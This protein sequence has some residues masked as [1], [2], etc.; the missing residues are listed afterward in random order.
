MDNID[1]SKKISGV[2]VNG[3]NMQFDASV[4]ANIKAENIKDGV[5][6]LGVEGTFEGG[7]LQT[8]QISIGRNGTTVVLPDNGFFGLEKVEII[9][10]V[11]PSDNAI[12]G[13]SW[14]NDAT[15]TMTRTDDAEDMTYAI[16][17]GRVASDFDNVFPYNQM[18]RTTID[19]NVFVYVPAMFL[20]LQLTKITR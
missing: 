3:V 1:T 11:Q 14:T 10:D 7:T 8:K 12:Y 9:T 13:V 16:S 18:K 5:S 17:G 6:I 2:S 20:E 4:D 19:G 15:T